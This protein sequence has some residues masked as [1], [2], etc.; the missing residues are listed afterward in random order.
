ME[1][2]QRTVGEEADHDQQLALNKTPSSFGLGLRM[3]V[4]GTTP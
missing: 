4:A 3:N 1:G 2:G